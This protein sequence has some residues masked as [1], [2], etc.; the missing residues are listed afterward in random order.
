MYT[1][2]ISETLSLLPVNELNGQH[3]NVSEIQ[4][5]LRGSRA[6]SCCQTVEGDWQPGYRQPT[7]V[8][9]DVARKG[10]DSFVEHHCATLLNIV[11]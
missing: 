5:E 9:A 8:A 6:L 4:S 1:S 2:C 3:D 11:S 7:P 10:G